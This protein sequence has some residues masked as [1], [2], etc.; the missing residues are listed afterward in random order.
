MIFDDFPIEILIETKKKVGHHLEWSHIKS[1]MCSVIS[2]DNRTRIQPVPE[3]FI[4]F[5]HFVTRFPTLGI[6][7]PAPPPSKLRPSELVSSSS[8]LHQQSFNKILDLERPGPTDQA[9]GTPGSDKRMGTLDGRHKSY[10]WPTHHFN[11]PTKEN[12]QH[13]EHLKIL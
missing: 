3:H 11:C 1:K 5:A 9:Q 2:E 10:E 8:E 7:I 4:H 12:Q 6:S 13:Q